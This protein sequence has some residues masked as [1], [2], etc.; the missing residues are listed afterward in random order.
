MKG[1]KT[2]F[3][4][5][6]TVCAL[7]SCN[8]NALV[9]TFENIPNENWTYVKPI[10]TSL[11]VSDSTKGYNIYVNFRHNADY[12]YANIWLRIHVIGPDKKDL[13]ERQ[14][15]QLALPNG[16]W[17]GKGSGNL[18][19]YQLIYKEKYRFGKKGTYQILV[20]Q[21][22]RDNPLKGISDVGIRIEEVE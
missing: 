14:E 21:N 20:E 10:K 11:E 13:V 9:D 4:L 7:V 18:Y 16:E 15:F 2:Y 3:I 8:N 19:S 12:R 5:L 1:L 17:L 22:M 6:A